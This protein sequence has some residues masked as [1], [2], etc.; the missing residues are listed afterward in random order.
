MTRTKASWQGAGVSSRR[1]VLLAGIA[2]A[3]GATG[4]RAEGAARKAAGAP[5]RSWRL[6]IN[7]AFTGESNLFILTT[8]YR[9][10][11]DYVTSQMRERPA[12]SVEPVV[13]VTRF[14]ELAQ[15]QEKPELVFGKSVNQLA[16]LVRDNG[17]QPL[18]RRQNRITVFTEIFFHVDHSA[19]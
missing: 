9:P 2:T 19:N 17:Y 18:V 6:L 3:L 12:I 15:A 8:R 4:A 16:K 13:N 11:A 7:E 10:F 5:D 1:G 14:L